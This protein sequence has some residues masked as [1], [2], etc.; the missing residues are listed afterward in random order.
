MHSA[1]FLQIKNAWLQLE[2]KR[3]T[4][5]ICIIYAYFNPKNESCGSKNMKILLFR[6]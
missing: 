6:V 2:L 4:A 3:Y 5:L 1:V